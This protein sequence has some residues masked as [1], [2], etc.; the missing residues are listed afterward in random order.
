VMVWRSWLVVVGIYHVVTWVNMAWNWNRN[1]KF[2]FWWWSFSLELRFRL[3]LW[4][5]GFDFP[6]WL[7]VLIYFAPTRVCHATEL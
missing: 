2:N 5:Y 4:S 1:S 3:G 7:S 6:F